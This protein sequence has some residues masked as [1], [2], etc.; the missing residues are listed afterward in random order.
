MEVF[1]A[2]N[3][4]QLLPQIAAVLQDGPSRA[5]NGVVSRNSRNGP[6]LVFD[7]P[8]CFQYRNPAEKVVFWAPRDCNPFF[9][10]FE[11]LWMLGGRNDVAYVSKFSKQIAQ[12]S[13]NSFTFHGAYGYRWRQHFGRDQLPTIIKRLKDNPEDRRCVLEMWDATVDGTGNGKDYPCNLVACFS[14]GITGALD[15]T[16]YNRSNDIVLGALG[17]NCVHFAMLQEYIAAG[18]GCP[19]GR[20]SQVSNNMHAYEANVNKILP[21]VEVAGKISRFDP[22]QNGEVTPWPLVKDFARWNQ[23]LYW[24]LDQGT[25]SIGYQEPFFRALA[26]PLL[27]AHQAFSKKEDPQRFNKAL[28]VLINI[29][30]STWGDVSLPCDWAVAATQ[31]VQRRKEAALNKKEEVINAA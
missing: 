11:S 5:A 6:V 22:Y 31:W 24:F 1:K 27:A 4:N 15:M 13:D 12:Y 25:N 19:L 2:R 29:P 21:L 9:H 20:Y 3:A 16:V 7:A 10:F 14:R 18:I 26:V 8:V 30:K 28:E 23:E 17:A